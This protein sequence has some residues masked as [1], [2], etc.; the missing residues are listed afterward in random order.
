MRTLWPS[1]SSFVRLLGL[2]VNA[3]VCTHCV[4]ELDVDESLITETRLIAVVSEPAEPAPGETVQ[5]TAW[6]AGPGGPVEVNELTWDLC[7]R[8]PSL[9]QSGT[10]DLAC[11]EQQDSSFVTVG[12]GNP[13]VAVIP[14]D[15]CGRFGPDPPPVEPGQTAGRPAI[16][17]STGGYQ[18]AV[19]LRTNA[20]SSDERTTLAQRVVCG[21]AGATQAEAAE[22]RQRYRPN[23]NPSHLTLR[24][25]NNTG[26]EIAADAAGQYAIPAGQPVDLVVR[27][28]SCTEGSSC[29]GREYF[30]HYDTDSR[31]SVPRRES[32]RV[33]W[34]ATAP[35]LES[36]R[37]GV[38]SD[39]DEDLD[40]SSNRFSAPDS[41]H[42]VHLWVVAR[43]GRGGVH[44]PLHVVL[45]VGQ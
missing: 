28:P 18:Q 6:F 2:L 14:Q 10:V 35:G 23:T 37:T 32:M 11:L 43:D 3:G 1:R 42:L 36:A 40:E 5:W 7:T 27:W 31:Q 44:P 19:V 26:D 8:R 24:V 13:A 25:F 41:P 9:A 30:V 12:R 4:P 29:G 20:S 38:P 21:L 45:N 15:T 33:A 17:D 34:S 22:F 39:V 16:P